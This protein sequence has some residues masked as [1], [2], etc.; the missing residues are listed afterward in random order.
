M[1][2]IKVNSTLLLIALIWGVGFVPQREGMDF[3]SPALFNGWRFIIGA[4][5]LLPLLLYKKEFSQRA[6][7]APGTLLASFVLGLL[8]FGGATL[9][10]ISIQYTSLA[11]VAFITG[12]YVIIVPVIGLV[13]GERYTPIV[14][15]GG[16]LALVGLYL[17]TG[18][19]GELNIKGD[20]YCLIG[21][22]FWALHL[23]ALARFSPHHSVLL[24]AFYQ[25]VFCALLS[26]GYVLI[27][28]TTQSFTAGLI[29]PVVNGIF[30][31]GVSYTLQVVVMEYA[32]PFIAALVFSLE[33]VFGAMVGYL[34]YAETLPFVALVGA[35]LMLVGC[36]LAQISSD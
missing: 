29:W 28:E 35:V 26:V 23:L 11:N 31:V 22:V 20:V 34:V 33:S 18:A 25:F 1:N 27:F 2:P 12:L 30:A 15:A 36:V 7:L 21:A 32:K 10:Q 14:W 9:Q 8:L 16:I 24:L 6:G 13:L 5:C 3:M 19:G 17:L 4:L